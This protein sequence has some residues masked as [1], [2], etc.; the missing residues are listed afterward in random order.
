MKPTLT[1]DLVLDAL[2]MAI[3][4]RRPRQS[5]IVHSDQGS[6]YG[7][8]DAVRFFKD[9]HLIPSMSRRGNCYDNAVEESFFSSLKKERIRRRIY[10]SREEARADVFDYIEVFYNRIRRHSHLGQM[11]PHDFEQAALNQA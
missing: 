5:V 1:R 3:W 11:S 2:L 9:H 8:D 6:Q 7:S 4:R 10:R